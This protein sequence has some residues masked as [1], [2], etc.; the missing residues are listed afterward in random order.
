MEI[1]EMQVKVRIE[2]DVIMDAAMMAK[3]FA[4]M[5]SNDQAQFLALVHQQ[6]A[7]YTKEQAD[8]TMKEQGSYGREMQM[9]Y[10]KDHFDEH[11]DAKEFIL[12]LYQMTIEEEED[13]F[14]ARPGGAMEAARL[15]KV[16]VDT[17]QS[18]S[19]THRVRAGYLDPTFQPCCGALWEQDHKVGCPSATSWN[20]PPGDI[21]EDMRKAKA[22]IEADTGLKPTYALSAQAKKYFEQQGMAARDYA[23]EYIGTPIE[24]IR[25]EELVK[26]LKHEPPPPQEWL[27]PNGDVGMPQ[28]LEV[29]SESVSWLDKPN[30]ALAPISQPR[31]TCYCKNPVGTW[32]KVDDR[33]YV[34]TPTPKPRPGTV[35]KVCADGNVQVLLDVDMVNMAPNTF[36]TCDPTNLNI[37]G[38]L[39]HIGDGGAYIGRVVEWKDDGMVVIEVMP[40][41]KSDTRVID[42]LDR[43]KK[44]VGDLLT[45]DDIASYTGEFISDKVFPKVSPSADTAPNVTER[46]QCDECKGTGTW[47]SPFSN[48]T[49]PC[50][51]G[52]KS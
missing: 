12:S 32:F 48:E 41:A 31:I 51:R 11:P 42:F 24:D 21:M 3:A 27:L 43:N 29:L 9:L 36:I 28:P 35:T 1:P 14:T 23:Q 37:V 49:S 46:R 38:S 25:D 19:R 4:H 16:P 2:T 17:V 8:G 5:G 44:K 13:T 33:V 40:R 18:E 34:D 22:A 6:M 47:T 50:S 26:A 52:C 7:T 39:A 30:D 20:N 15:P 45:S 10:I